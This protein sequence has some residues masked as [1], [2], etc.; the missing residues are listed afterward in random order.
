MINNPP[1]CLEVCGLDSV[2]VPIL[3]APAVGGGGQEGGRRE[4]L[5]TA[6][7]LMLVTWTVGCEGCGRACGGKQHTKT[8]K[9]GAAQGTRGA[10]D[11][12]GASAQRCVCTRPLHCAN[13]AVP[14]PTS[15]LLALQSCTLWS[16]CCFQASLGASSPTHLSVETHRIIIGNVA[17]MQRSRKDQPWV[18]VERGCPVHRNCRKTQF[19]PNCE[20]ESSYVL[21]CV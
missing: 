20:R 12:G 5:C 9:S 2:P 8:P 10:G 19:C 3:P 7:R 13:A 15:R 11:G 18:A 14:L 1:P 17:E 6:S 21:C 16:P 4:L